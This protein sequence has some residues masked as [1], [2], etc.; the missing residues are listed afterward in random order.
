MDFID[1]HHTNA[2]TFLLLEWKPGQQSWSLLSQ[3]HRYNSLQTAS[4]PRHFPLNTTPLMHFSTDCHC[5][6]ILQL[7]PCTFTLDTTAP[8][9]FPVAII[10][11]ALTFP[12]NP[13]NF[14]WLENFTD[15]QL[16]MDFSASW[17]ASMCSTR[18]DA[19]SSPMH[20]TNCHCTWKLY[21]Q[22]P[23]H[24]FPHWPTHFSASWHSINA[25]STN[26]CP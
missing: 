4:A 1:H 17:P 18:I 19:L 22:T 5:I 12:M 6:H 3:L 11:S 16:I 15:R 10:T 24:V 9:P 23:Y 2:S 13:T 20:P 8:T 25:F 21:R 26:W 14:H 7:H